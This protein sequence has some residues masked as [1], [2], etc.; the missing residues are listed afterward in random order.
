MKLVDFFAKHP[1]IALAF[2]G[3][4]DSSYLLYAAKK[5]G[6]DVKAYYAKSDFQPEFEFEDAKRLAADLDAD[7]E[8]IYLDVLADPVIVSNPADRCYTCK[9]HIMG[10]IMRRTAKDG[11]DLIVDGTNASDDLSDRPGVK[12]LMELGIRSPLLE[13]GLTKDEIRR[14][15][16]EAGLFT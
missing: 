11:Y 14:L 10:A 6:A 8:V 15:S 5:A 4:V 13:A 12:T 3:G 9:K 2:S 1:K 7:M 16:K